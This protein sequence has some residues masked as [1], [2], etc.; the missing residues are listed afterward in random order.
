MSSSAVKW[1]V[2]R[3][4]NYS[5]GGNVLEFNEGVSEDDSVK[6]DGYILTCNNFEMR[7]LLIEAS[8]H[9]VLIPEELPNLPENC[10]PRVQRK[11]DSF[12]RNFFGLCVWKH[13]NNGNCWAT[14]LS[15]DSVKN[16]QNLRCFKNHVDSIKNRDP[17]L[18]VQITR[19]GDDDISPTKMSSFGAN[20]RNVLKNK[21]IWN[22]NSRNTNGM[23]ANFKVMLDKIGFPLS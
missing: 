22:V 2:A 1:P 5:D 14:K 21:I 23:Y 17:E 13:M 8:S 15:L 18:W 12:L 6:N 19:F 16:P 9:N 10:H 7:D 20:S 3:G 4:N 11:N